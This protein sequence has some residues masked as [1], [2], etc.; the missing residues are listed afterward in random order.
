MNT[1]IYNNMKIICAIPMFPGVPMM[2]TFLYTQLQNSSIFIIILH[3][4]QKEIE[5]GLINELKVNLVKMLF[6]QMCVIYML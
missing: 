4:K 6:F 1:E 3:C 5:N 2:I